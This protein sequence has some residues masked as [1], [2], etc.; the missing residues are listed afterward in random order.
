MQLDQDN[1]TSLGLTGV[2]LVRLKNR[3]KY[4]VIYCA[5]NDLFVAMLEQHVDEMCLRSHDPKK[6]YFRSLIYPVGG[7]CLAPM[8]CGETNF[9]PICKGLVF[10]RAKGIFV[11]DRKVL[12]SLAAL[13]P[14]ESSVVTNSG[15]PFAHR[16]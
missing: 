3:V 13:D 11:R 10:D 14:G 1:S 2:E 12:C 7:G 16:P 8:P 9:S 4:E 6:S 5:Q 15:R